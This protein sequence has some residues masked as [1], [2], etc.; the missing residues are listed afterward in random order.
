MSE[1]VRLSACFFSIS[2]VYGFQPVLVRH[3]NVAALNVPKFRVEA[4]N[5]VGFTEF[6]SSRL[7]A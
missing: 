3:S 1:I 2:S 6:P 7:D 5:S 4:P